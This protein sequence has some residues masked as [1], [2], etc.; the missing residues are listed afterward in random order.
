MASSTYPSSTL[1]HPPPVVNSV[2]EG[3]LASFPLRF[4]HATSLISPRVTLVGD[5][6]HTIHPLAGQGLNLGLADASSLASTISYAV[7]HGMDIGDMFALERY[8]SERFGKGLLMAGGV[9]ALNWMYQVGGQGEGVVSAIAGRV[10]GVGMKVLGL[11][12]GVRELVMKQA[13]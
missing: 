2:Q 13:S 8:N 10:R 5:A 12:P 1:S 9:D 4:R 7:E 6:A 3:T 11:V